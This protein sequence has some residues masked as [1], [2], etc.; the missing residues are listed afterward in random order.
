MSRFS[1]WLKSN[2]ITGVFV[3][4]PAVLT[5]YI[6]WGII[7]K[8]DNMLVPLI[9]ES[10]RPETLLGMN[11]PGTGAVAGFILMIIIGMIARNFIGKR[12]VTLGEY[13]MSSIPG[14]NWLYHTIKQITE[15]IAK[16]Q[17]DAFR[18][19]VMVE[20]PR[21]GM[22][23]IAFVTGTTKGEVQ[24]LT[25]EEMVNIFLPTTPNPTSGFLLFVPKRDL[26]PLQMSVEEATKMIIS[27]G[28]VTPR[29]PEDKDVI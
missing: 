1:Q 17:K 29:I 19:A 21:K 24:D 20:Y 3:T 16:S 9:P 25:K 18:E 13:F 2:A 10:Y 26:K 15:T 28:I 23:C 14:V 4:L 22:W 6:F 8:L 7:A 12:F 27:A 11:I 5:I